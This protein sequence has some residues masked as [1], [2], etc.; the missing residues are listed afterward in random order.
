MQTPNLAAVTC[1]MCGQSKIDSAGAEHP[2]IHI[3]FGGFEAT[4]E[5]TKSMHLDCMPHHV[6]QAHIAA[7]HGPEIEAARAGVR[8]DDLRAILAASAEK[9]AADEGAFLA[10]A[11]ID[12]DPV[13]VSDA[14]VSTHALEA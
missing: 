14:P 13:S 6:A 8:G 5:S 11:V 7:G 10:S 2:M 4:S 3:A 9:R 1:Y 12:V